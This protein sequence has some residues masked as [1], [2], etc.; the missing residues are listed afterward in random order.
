[1][2]KGHECDHDG[3]DGPD[4]VE[5]NFD[6]VVS[7]QVLEFSRPYLGHLAL[8][9]SLPSKEFDHSHASE[10]LVHDSCSLIASFHELILRRNHDLG[11]EVIE[12]QRNCREW[13]SVRCRE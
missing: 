8:E 4:P 13:R 11:R 7:T 1:M 2:E 9:F 10:D 3:G 6:Q 5:N 12:R